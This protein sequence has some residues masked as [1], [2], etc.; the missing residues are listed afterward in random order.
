MN[1][2]WPL[3]NLTVIGGFNSDFFYY[4]I[5]VDFCL[6]DT[7]TL[8]QNGVMIQCPVANNP[9]P[10]PQFSIITAR[11]FLNSS[12]NLLFSPPMDIIHLNN[13]ILLLLFE[14]EAKSVLNIT[15]RVFNRF[16]SDTATTIIR[17]CG[18]LVEVNSVYRMSHTAIMILH[19]N[20]NQY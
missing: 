5:G 12:V 2:Y 7:N 4:T 11:I 18:M 10:P 3:Y 8:P 15:C 20:N 6:E 17:A 14:E 16:G 19:N 13:S 9:S 1:L